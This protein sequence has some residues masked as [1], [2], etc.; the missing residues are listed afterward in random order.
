MGTEALD[1]LSND[2][3]VAAAARGELSETQV[4]RLVAR[5]PELAGLALIAAMQAIGQLRRP[6]LST[7]SGQR[8]VYEKPKTK[9]GGKGRRGARPGHRG[10][11]REKPEQIDRHEHHEPLKR[12]P[13][14][15]EAVHP[16]H[17][18]RRRIIIDMPTSLGCEA[19]EHTIPRQWCGHCRRYVEPTVP[20][21]MPKATLGHGTV[22]S[23]A[24]FHYGLGI[25]MEHIVQ[26][27]SV[28]LSTK[29]TA[30]GLSAMW[31]RL[32]VVLAPWYEA[33]AEQARGST[34]LHADETGWRV[35]GR[36]HWLWCFAN[37]R[38]CYYMIDPSRGS[39]ALRKFFGE[40]WFDGVLISDFWSAY[41]SVLAADQ[42]CCL[43]HLLRELHR[44]DERNDASSWQGFSKKLKRLIRD[45][46]RLRTRED[47][48]RQRYHSRVQRIDQRLNALADASYSDA[49]AQRLGKRIDRYRDSLF[50]F[51]DYPEVRWENNFAE[52]QLRPAV[53][54]RK[55]SQSNRSEKGA[56]TQAI[57][58]SVFRTLKLRGLDPIATLIDALR[59][60]VRDG[61]LPPLPPP[62]SQAGE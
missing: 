34:Y 39:P 26:I 58:M 17:K 9:G 61:Q 10:Q 8:P 32:A 33:L 40:E 48:D 29:L 6:D 11:R 36:T 51:L 43:V 4:R 19:T 28:H 18:H 60:H 46:I 42:Q 3:V 1:R 50:T 21:A 27:F 45:G 49:D 38:V 55:N 31:Q 12:C 7:P 57:L 54:L 16:P 59:S 25:T 22:A 47:Y 56:A 23:T 52:R 2:Q 14:C 35:D 53:I 15:G 62:P 44:V 24:W 37:E 5:D 20:D 30:G 41:G 13:C